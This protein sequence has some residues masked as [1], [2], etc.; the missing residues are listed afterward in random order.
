MDLKL[1]SACGVGRVFTVEDLKTVVK[2]KGRFEGIKWSYVPWLCEE[3]L[4]YCKGQPIVRKKGIRHVR[5]YLDELMKYKDV[6]RGEIEEISGL[7]VR[8]EG[9][10][11]EQRQNIKGAEAKY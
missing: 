4:W 9:K 3:R 1:N 2:L 5:N 6:F 10:V 8:L 7:A 11:R